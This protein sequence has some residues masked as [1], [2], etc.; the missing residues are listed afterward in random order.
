MI[1]LNV[2]A[3]TP[4]KTLIAQEAPDTSIYI[5]GGLP[6]SGLP[7]AFIVIEPNGGIRTNA[8][9]FGNASCVLSVSVYVALLT[10][11]A[12]NITKENLVI[13]K[14]QNLFSPV[15]KATGFTYE[16]MKNPIMYSGKSIV[17]GYSTKIININ[18]FI[19]Y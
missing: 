15:V 19:N 2:D 5:N 12:T 17:S 14:F 1:A 7:S 8:T 3:A 11:G 16:I 4:L 9:K 6:S 13:G 18:C 10:T